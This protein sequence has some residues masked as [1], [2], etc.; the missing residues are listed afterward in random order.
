MFDGHLEVNVYEAIQATDASPAGEALRKE[1]SVWTEQRPRK[2]EGA[3][4]KTPR[5]VKKLS[6][7]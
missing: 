4:V 3:F 5:S 2:R 7:A 6:N 1:G